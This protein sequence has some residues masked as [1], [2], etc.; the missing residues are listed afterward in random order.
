M[1]DRIIL[2]I[3][4]LFMTN[5][6]YT[7][8]VVINTYSTNNAGQV[9]LEIDGESDKYYLLSAN[10]EPDLSYNSI[11]SMTLGQSGTMVISEPLAAFPLQNYTITAHPINDPLDTDGDGIDDIEEFNNRPSI[12]PLNYAEEIPFSDGIVSI[13]AAET[14]TELAVVNDDIPWAP[15]LN[16]Q[17][18]VKFVIVEE[19]SDHPK[20]Y[21]INSKTHYVHNEFLATIGLNVYVDDV[22]T[23]EIVYNPNEI[24][25]NGV[26]GSYSFNYSFG[27]ARPFTQTQRTF[28]LLAANMP[29]LTNNLQHFIGSFSESFY[30]DSYQE[31]F[32]GSRIRVV[33]ESEVFEDVDFLPFNQA[34]GYGYFR[35]MELDE[36]PG[37]R[38][39]V[40]YDALPNSL[41]RVGGI[42]TSVIQTPLSH[43]N[44][45]AIQ[46][47]VPN[48]YIKNPL[49][50]DSIAN[51]LGKYIYY[52][53]EN[54]KYLI[55]EADI[56]EVNEWYEKLRPTQ[57]QIPD[58]D[59]SMQEIL[60]LDSINFTMS[61]SFGAKCSNVATMRNF[62]FPEGTIPNG[63]GIPFYYYDEFMKF[64]GFYQKAR[65]MISDPDFIS[66]LETRIEALKDFRKD[67]KQADMPLWML[68]Q[69]QEMHESFPVGTSIRCRSSTNNEDLPGFS[70]AGL[71]T[72]KTQH[73][74]EGHI[75]KSIKQVYASMW[76]FRA[77][78]ERDFYRINHDIAAMGVLCHPNYEDEKSNGVGVSID[79]I[80]S[81]EN[82]FYLN[83][84]VGEFLITNP[85]GN[86]RPEEILLYK[87]PTV[88]FFVIRPSNLVA[89]GEL[90]MNEDYLNQM[91]IYLQVIHDEFAILYN[92]EGAEGFG[93]DI[94]YKVTRE[95]QLIIKQARPW[96][97]FWADI[98]ASHDLAVTQVIE[99]HSSGNLGNSEIVT[100][101]I[102]NLGLKNM[103]DFD[104]TLII[105]GVNKETLFI[106]D[107]LTPRSSKEFTFSLPQ[108]FS[109][110][111]DYDITIAV[112]HNEDSYNLNDSLHIVLSHLHPLEAEIEAHILNASCGNK[113]EANANITN[114]GYQ[115]F[116]EVGIEIIVNNE[117]IDTIIS[118]I[119]LMSL[120][121][122]DL[123]ILITQN[124]KEIENEV[125]LNL[126]SVNGE[127]DAL[128][129]NNSSTFIAEKNY[130]L[131]FITLIIDADD[132]PQETSWTIHRED[133]GELINQGSLE[134]QSPGITLDV[135]LDYYECYIL[136]LFDTYGDG[137]CCGF[138]MGS[139]ELLNSKG[140]ILLENDGDFGN[141][142]IEAFCPRG[143]CL[144]T[145]DVS[146]NDATNENSS[147]GSI[148]INTNNG[149]SPFQYSID[150]GESF[151]EDNYFDG[152][153][154]G[155][156]LIEVHDATDDCTYKELVEIEFGTVSNTDI[157]A[158][159]EIKIFPNPT[160]NDIKIEVAQNSILS[161][162]VQFEVYNNLG[163]RLETFK[164]TSVEYKRG[165]EISLKEYSSGTYFIKCI[166]HHFEKYYK[167]IKI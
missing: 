65:D 69:L 20:V 143:D 152:L 4:I 80:Y 120:N 73:P 60:P 17:Q 6:C 133:T 154:P 110:I 142:A 38:D 148:L 25:P 104:L 67:I 166:N 109:E 92:V 136:T 78:D 93:M 121:S 140:D 95:D 115:T 163:R 147:N 5:L 48:A 32:E 137:I 145:A 49:F 129:D 66:D 75:S 63:F 99:P 160:N 33:L 58:R 41:P 22:T 153:H 44:L 167:L 62:G 51:L 100:A 16:G 96:V 106:E 125:T 15:F 157:L 56:D 64:N 30:I 123:T 91:R 29:F 156:Y 52:K 82:S 144:L 83:T 10:H 158:S 119:D 146:V 18:F 27:N 111:K 85:H 42:M 8:E 34:E 124:I 21:F 70:G 76:N 14:F 59:L 122:T 86:S 7:Q 97:S 117:V 102:E 161:G 37:S 11:T 138:G 112:F 150:G 118:T 24:L 116:N 9:Q 141:S 55:R 127:Q 113:I 53:V 134:H 2:L 108:D 23:G 57:E 81:T 107:E 84:Q 90:V 50:I 71:Y 139:F 74:D 47:N 126:I 149:V 135:C 98:N 43:V 72:S 36:N 61:T 88:G 77:F 26:S 159:D 54:D 3:V 87:D 40:L 114:L 101:K 45:R 151:E 132:Y 89:H 130:N 1:K 39:I 105:D 13:I 28:E 131:D 128:I 68:D 155:S 12:S 162:D 165:M 94:E 19:D 46:D 164:I 79:P 31:D 35:K 103:K